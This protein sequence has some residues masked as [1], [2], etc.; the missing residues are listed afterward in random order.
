MTKRPDRG[1]DLALQS[2]DWFSIALPY[3]EHGQRV[4]QGLGGSFMTERGRELCRRW[5]TLAGWRVRKDNVMSYVKTGFA[6]AKVSML[7]LCLVPP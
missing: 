5:L 2:L 4:N 7:P 3:L 6:L 1:R